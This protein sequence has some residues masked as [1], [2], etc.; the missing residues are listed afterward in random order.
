MTVKNRI[1]GRIL[2]RVII[3][4]TIILSGGLATG[5]GQKQDRVWLEITPEEL[6]M[7]D[8]PE[9]PGAAA[10]CLYYEYL[11]DKKNDVISVY[12]RIKV[13]TPAGRDLANLEIYFN[14]DFARIKNLRVRV[15]KPDGRSEEIKPNV[16]EKVAAKIGSWERRVKTVAIPAVATGDI[17]EYRYDKVPTSNSKFSELFFEFDSLL[18]QS[19]R[20]T[21][22]L[23]FSSQLVAH[24]DLQD[25]LFIKRAKYILVRGS[26][27]IFV[28]GGQGRLMWISNKL[29][30]VE[31]KMTDKELILEVTNIP[32]F[33]IEEYMPP[34]VTQKMNMDLYL[35]DPKLASVDEYWEKA[36]E[37]W[38]KDMNEFMGKPEELKKMAEEVAGGEPDQEARLKKIYA[39]VQ[40][41]RNLSYEKEIS[42]QE[43]KKIK[44][45][46]KVADV[47]KNNYGYKREITR[48]FV[49]LARAA[50][51][52]AYLVRVVSRDDKL[53][54]PNFPLFETQ[55]DSEMAMVRL[56]N[57]YQ[58]FD[59]GTL[60]CPFGLIHWT[61][62]N[63][64][65]M[66][67]E[68]G[69][70]VMFNAPA[71]SPEQAVARR[72]VSLTLNEQ[73]DLVGGIVASYEG[74][75]ALGLK[76]DFLHE[77]AIKIK[78]TL[79][80]RLKDD[81]PAGASV[82]M[83]NITGLKSDSSQ[84]RVEYEISLPGIVQESGDRV[85]LP[86][87]PLIRPDSYPFRSGTRKYN[88]YYEYPY[89]IVDEVILNLPGKL[90]VEG[91]PEPR[92][93]SSEFTDYLLEVKAG[94]PGQVRVLRQLTVK[95]SMISINHFPVLK[96]FF[97]FVHFN[98]E[99]Q[100]LLKKSQR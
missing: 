96:D 16:M 55:F 61:R 76:L 3:I 69:R 98:D 43:S 34:P 4:V 46:K 87:Y 15:T 30:G 26:M 56:G 95:K 25:N 88:I 2:I 38:Q 92:G 10:V 6:A 68:H 33:E 91:L 17:I 51:F 82:T 94:E 49:A 71:L 67:F 60:F 23:D 35:I 12:K 59:P 27:F 66:A 81:L 8:C 47:L 65:A 100:L 41:I 83:K 57:S 52:D 45:N 86:A 97:E 28:S 37:A 14:P 44:E 84:V 21:P 40:Q 77:D 13:L 53:Y 58:P 99:Q 39:R 93:K 29:K 54:R 85:I 75:E 32:P 78:E 22:P 42:E 9:Y 73:G 19:D 50:G 7:K 63:T 72:E 11:D 5:M 48:T 89:Q 36:A 62:S 64:M 18:T 79:E 90:M 31:P 70:M 24:W 80:T 20:G 74:Q 1:P